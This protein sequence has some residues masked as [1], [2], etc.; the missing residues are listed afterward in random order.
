MDAFISYRRTASVWAESI[1]DKLVER[2]A[3]VFLDTHEIKN[4]DF[5]EMIEWNIEEAPNFILILS[6][7]SFKEQEGDIDYYRWEIEQAIKK[8]KNIIAIK[9][10]SFDEK[11][12]IWD[13]ESPEIAKLKTFNNNKYSMD[14]QKTDIE[15]IISL[16]KDHDGYQWKYVPRDNTSWYKTHTVTEKD[17]LWMR[18]N[19][20]VCRNLDVNL[21]KTMMDS[22][23]WKDTHEDAEEINYFCLDLYDPNALEK[24]ICTADHSTP[25]INVFGFCHDMTNLDGNNT[26]EDCDKRFGKN[27]FIDCC[28]ESEYEEGLKELLRLNNIPYFDVIECTLILKDCQNP[29]RVL[30]ILQSFLNPKGGFI[31][32]R[33]LDDDFVVAFPDND[34]YI[35]E[36]KKMIRKDPAA[37]NRYLG[38]QLYTLFQKSGAK[39]VYISDE[40]VSTAN[41]IDIFEKED[42]CDAYFSYLEPEFL[43]LTK[44][45]PHNTRYK[46][47]YEYIR[48]NYEHVLNLF[49]SNDFYFRA[50]YICGYAFYKQKRRR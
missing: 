17:V 47:C 38:K 1:R 33:D 24:K 4:D 45:N 13:K 26:I 10:G 22:D 32:A 42:I 41:C 15:N 5:S 39:D 48:D 36:M 29:L 43:A 7:D 9:V 3:D 49:S 12:V 27:H 31:Y 18:K 19:Y 46:K 6:Y 37:G 25:K 23:E 8:K 14:T 2:N 16:M 30:S 28:E 44:D 40:C 11:D 20:Q 50:G 21:L 34:G 35:H